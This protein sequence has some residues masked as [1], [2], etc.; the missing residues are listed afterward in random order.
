[1]RNKKGLILFF[2]TLF[3]LCFSTILY[4]KLPSYFLQLEDKINDIMFLY[5]G[6]KKADNNIVIVDI[7]EKSLKELG[8]WPWSRDKVAKIIQNLTNDGA[9]IIGLDIVFAEED[10]SSPKKI[11]KKLGLKVKGV[12]DYDEILV[13]SIKN[14]PTVVGYVFTLTNDGIKPVST[15]NLDAIVIEKNKPERS[16]IIKAYRAIL[17]IPIIQKNANANGYFNTI[18]DNDGVVR[19]IPMLISFKGSL[20]PSL[21]LEIIRNALQE[22]IIKVNYE[23]SG[24][25]SI[26]IGN[27]TIP[28]DIYG[29]MLINYTGVQK[30]YRYI[31][32]A[33]IY[34]N[35]IDKSLIANK[36]IL[37]GTSAAGL[38]DLRS[39]P[40]DS[41]YPGVEIHANALDNMINQNFISI[42]MWA[43]VADILSLVIAAF[44]VLTLLLIP[45]IFLS[46][47]GIISLDFVLLYFH[48][49]LMFHKGVMLNTLFPLVEINLLFFIGTAINLFYENRQKKLI[50]SK[51]A[52]KVSPAVV[53][54][55]LKENK[56]TLEEEREIT[57]FFSDIRSFTTISEQIGSPSKL[58]SL[59]NDYMTPMVDII[60]KHNGTVDKFIGDAIMAYWNAPVDIK[61][62]ADAALEASIEQIIKLKE[63]REILK[64]RYDSV[65]DIGI[66]LNSGKSIVGEMGSL[67]RSD[68]T[69]IGDPVNLAS[70]A[71]G[72]CKTYSA[73]II[74]THFTKKL[75]KKEHY[76]LRE[77]DFV[78]VKGKNKPV[79]IYECMGTKDNFW[80][81]ID[82]K[83]MQLYN[84]ALFLYRNSYFKQ[85]FCIFEDLNQKN[86]QKLYELYMQRCS[87]F[88]KNPPKN[89]DG[90]FA[91]TK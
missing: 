91:T 71:E 55:L 23:N 38:L 49:Y 57:I 58:V 11:V 44:L 17:N 47:I 3:I 56:T 31:S 76:L 14:S 41:A 65:I 8:Q 35:N 25:K 81:K 54:K 22:K 83:Q 50:K 67:G 77:L 19:S 24:V 79:K 87:Y 68:Y 4:L 20:Y 6:E 40:F 78:K 34:H 70:R 61:E 72:L 69:C 60:T 5:R 48:Y 52:K 28:T 1:M 74:L 85:A 12:E 80:V 39:I 10:N 29:R 27:I 82:E 88:I 84:K 45:N 90:I 9:G 64:K 18:P 7:D 51:F 73:K 37:I 32:A 2:S 26:T 36:I 33:D 66:G 62:H 89:F 42:P 21:S 53:E 13:K 16:Y 59:L 43:S 46:L 75:L 63:M 86:R 15:P 30:K